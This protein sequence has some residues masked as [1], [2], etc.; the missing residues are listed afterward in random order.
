[1]YLIA[2]IEQQMKQYNTILSINIVHVSVIGR[3][4]IENSLFMDDIN[5]NTVIGVQ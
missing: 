3:W 2:Q 4:S 5:N 1:M